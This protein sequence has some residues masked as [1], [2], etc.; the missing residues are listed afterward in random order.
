MSHFNFNVPDV[1]LALMR[2]YT[3]VTTE[4]ENRQQAYEDETTHGT[5]IP[6]QQRWTRMIAREL[7]TKET[8][9]L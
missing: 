6:Q 1:K 2:I 4:Y 7:G 9:G 8:A 5:I 3:E